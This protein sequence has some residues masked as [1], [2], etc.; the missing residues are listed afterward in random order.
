MD[1]EALHDIGYGMYV[2]GSKE[3]KKFD[4]LIANTVFQIT[5]KPPTI[6]ISITKSNLSYEYIKGSRVFTVSVL[7]QDAPLSF[8]GQLGFK[9]GR[10]PDKLKSMHYRAGQ[11]G[12]PIITDY[13]VSYLEARVIN[14]IG[15]GNHALFIGEVVNA[16][17][18]SHKTP[19]TYAYYHREK[20]GT[21]PETAP[22]YVAEK[23]EKV[24]GAAKYR[25]VVCGYIYDPAHG[26]PESGVKPGTPFEKLPDSWVCPIC[27][28][29][30]DQFEKVTE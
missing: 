28:V 21:T 19:L 26:D 7:N 24:S 17:V 1:T 18:L 5:S 3:D 29:G 15:I 16:E 13:A 12:A 30:K 2:I 8:I 4:A 14:E 9:S 22:T 11:T 20:R 23:K 6:A 27:G 25:C 10:D